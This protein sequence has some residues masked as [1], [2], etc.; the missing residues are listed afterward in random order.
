MEVK[1]FHFPIQ[2]IFKSNLDH[3]YLSNCNCNYKI[4]IIIFL[5]INESINEIKS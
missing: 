3:Y 2:K 5:M 4:K 1:I